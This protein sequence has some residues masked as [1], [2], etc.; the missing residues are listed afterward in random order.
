LKGVLRD[1]AHRAAA[2]LCRSPSAAPLKGVEIRARPH[3]V[4]ATLCRSP[5]AAPLKAY[6]VARDAAARSATLCRSPSAA[7]LKGQRGDATDLA[8]AHPLPITV[9]SPIEGLGDKLGKWAEEAYPL[10]ITVG[11]PI[12]G[13]PSI[14]RPSPRRQTLCRSPSAAPLKVQF[15]GA[16]VDERRHTLCRSPSAAPLKGDCDSSRFPAVLTLCRSPSAA[17]LKDY[18]SSGDV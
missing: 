16:D 15:L 10:P 12:E 5:S 13:R 11:S 17:P 1:A 8:R 7:P 9:G 18:Q 6:D 3:D 4:S 2:A 14:A